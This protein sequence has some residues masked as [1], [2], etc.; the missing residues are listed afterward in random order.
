MFFIFQILTEEV[1]A[2][3]TLE[4]Y[5]P[6]LDITRGLYGTKNRDEDLQ[7]FKIKS[8]KVCKH[9]DAVYIKL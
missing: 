6:Q 5:T 4:V 3:T 9:Y 8:I 2:N 1:I 7:Q